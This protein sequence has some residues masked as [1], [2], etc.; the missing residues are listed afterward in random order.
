MGEIVDYVSVMVGVW[1]FITYTYYTHYYKFIISNYLLSYYYHHNN[2]L[3]G[4][5]NMG[6]LSLLMNRGLIQHNHTHQLL[7]LLL[8]HYS[9]HYILENFWA[10]L[11]GRVLGST[12]CAELIPIQEF[13]WVVIS[14]EDKSSREI[15]CCTGHRLCL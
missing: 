10:V 11:I 13:S 4:T 14:G 9:K 15:V 2:P 12:I 6:S 5:L 8:S 7:L 1:K 3:S